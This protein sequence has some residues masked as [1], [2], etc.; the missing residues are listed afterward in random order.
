VFIEGNILRIIF[1]RI[2]GQEKL[3]FKRTLSDIG[4][5]QFV[6]IMTFR[7]QTGPE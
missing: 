3:R 6:K 2:T 4:Q 7:S 1:S 5:K